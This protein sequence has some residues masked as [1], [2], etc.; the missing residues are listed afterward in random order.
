[1]RVDDSLYCDTTVFCS[2]FPLPEV[3]QE[4]DL[5]VLEGSSRV[6]Q[7]VSQ[8]VCLLVSALSPVNHKRLYQ[9]GRRLF[10][11]GCIVERTNKGEIRTEE[12][13]E[14]ELSGELMD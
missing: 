10:V 11:K 14:I 1:M 12:Q 4:V 6:S 9:G 2:Y 7:S 13:S 5:H 8:L 3:N